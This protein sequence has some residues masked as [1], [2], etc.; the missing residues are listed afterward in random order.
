MESI[1]NEINVLDVQLLIVNNKVI[2]DI[3][4]KLT[5]TQTMCHLSHPILAYA[6]KIFH[7]A[8]QDD[9]AQLLMKDLQ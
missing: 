1:S 5:V 7:K 8:L 4:Y 2:T 3:Y 6:L 9:Y